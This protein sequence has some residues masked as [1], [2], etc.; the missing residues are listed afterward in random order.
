MTQVNAGAARAPTLQRHMNA[1]REVELRLITLL[2]AAVL[3][4]CAG[5]ARSDSGVVDAVEVDVR[6]RLESVDQ[7]GFADDALAST[8]RT[9]LGV[10]SAALHGVHGYLG[11]EDVRAVGDDRYNSTANGRTALPVVGDPED[12]EVDQAWLGWSNEWLQLR[13]GRQRI[14]LDNQ[15]FVGAVGFR[16]S[17]QTFDGTSAQA[18]FGA[19]T[20]FYGWLTNANR[21]FGEHHPDPARADMDLDA[22]LL[23]Y[24]HVLGPTKVTGY[25]YLLELRDLP[26]QSHYDA[27]VRFAGE[28]G[29][30]EWKVPFALEY[31]RQADY[32]DAPASVDADYLLVE[33]GAR[34]G[35]TTAKLG[36]EQ[37][38]GDGTYGFATPLAT[39]H[40]FNGWADRFLVT[41]AAGLR[42][43]YAQVAQALGAFDGVVAWHD[44]HADAGPARYGAEWNVAIG[45]KVL[46]H[47]SVRLE[48]AGYRADSL[49]TD[50]RIVWLTVQAV[51]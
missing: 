5:V 18:G 9:R 47:A 27:G 31:V 23:N 22:H 43:T 25:V 45:R 44:F 37:L 24:T 2:P 48:Y 36:Y 38:G 12:T 35:G 1:T 17:Q 28:P 3:A 20:L 32:A 4:A 21:V 49:G 10:R 39:L 40:A 6:Y 30:G 8:L 33:A 14:N 7:Q 51:F 16:Q 11:F 29:W 46:P 26:A 13:A 41:P 19:G 42:D 50:T 34:R 15:R